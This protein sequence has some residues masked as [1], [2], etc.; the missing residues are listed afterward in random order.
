M[1]LTDLYER[2]SDDVQ[3]LIIYIREAHPVDGLK[4]GR[5][6][7]Y[8]DP[9]TIEERRDLASECGAALKFGIETYVD[10][11]EDPV[12]T[13]YAAFP[14][15]LYLIGEDGNV[16]YQGGIGPGGFD[17]ADLE[18]AIVVELG[19]EAPAPQ[20]DQPDPPANEAT[21]PAGESDDS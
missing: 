11:I 1:S 2:Y 9:K 5:T 3:F 12:M 19:L 15:R 4:M 16:A 14:D 17:P 13:A 21:E 7:H 20:A 8:E 18:S 10:E 6:H